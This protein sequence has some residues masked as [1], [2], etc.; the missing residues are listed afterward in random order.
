MGNYEEL[1][2]AVA[3]VVKTNGNQEITGAN[4][5]NVLLT[6]ISTIGSNRLFAGVANPTTN[7]GTPD[8]NVFYLAINPGTYVNF[9]AFVLKPG[10][11]AV[12]TNTASG[13]V[14][15]DLGVSSARQTLAIMGYIDALSVNKINPAT[16]TIGSYIN[17]NDT[18]QPEP[19]YMHTSFIKVQPGKQYC[20]K[21]LGANY[22][23]I[24][25]YDMN[26]AQQPT[27]IPNN[28]SLGVA[29]FVIPNNTEYVIINLNKSTLTDDQVRAQMFMNEGATILYQPY[30]PYSP[31]EVNGINVNALGFMAQYSFDNPSGQSDN[32][33]ID[34]VVL[35]GKGNIN[36]R[37]FNTLNNSGNIA[38]LKNNYPVKVVANSP[39]SGISAY[40]LEYEKPTQTSFIFPWLG[41]Y[42]SGSIIRLWTN[43]NVYTQLRVHFGFERMNNTATSEFVSFLPSEIVAG[44]TKTQNGAISQITAKVLQVSN[45]YCQLEF[46]CLQKADGNY[47]I[48]FL[49]YDFG[50]GS[51]SVS[52]VKYQ[53]FGFDE[54]INKQCSMPLQQFA[55]ILPEK[56]NAYDE[57]I[58]PGYV[59]LLK[60][61]IATP[62]VSAGYTNEQI[63]N[64]VPDILV[65]YFNSTKK[66]SGSTIYPFYYPLTGSKGTFGIWVNKT[67]YAGTL[68]LQLSLMS[69]PVQFIYVDVLPADFVVGKTFTKTGG[70]STFTAAILATNGDYFFFEIDYN[71][72]EDG[73]LR[74]IPYEQ[75]ADAGA[76][77]GKAYTYVG[78]A[79]TANPYNNILKY[80]LTRLQ[81][82]NEESRVKLALPDEITFEFN[83]AQQIF[84]YCINKAFNYKN[85][86]IQVLLDRDVTSGKDY[87]RYFQYQPQVTGI[88]NATFQLYDNSRN[89]L[90]EKV[91]KFNVV[92][93][94]TQP[95]AMTTVLFIGDSLTFYNRITDEFYR[96]L[97]SDDARTITPDT[98]SIYDVV[99]YAGR[100]WGNIQL[101]GTQKQNYMGWVGQTYHEGYSGWDWSN[102]LKTGSP[103]FIGGAV[104]FNAYLTNNSFDTPNIIYIGLGW[105]DQKYVTETSPG[106]FDVTTVMA[107]AR[108]FLTALTTQLPNAK[109]RLWTENVPGTRGGIGN[110]PYGAVEW[111]D[112]Q[113]AK[114]IQIAIAEGYRE[115]IKDFPTVGIV[116]STAMI[117]SENSLQETNAGINTRINNTEVLGKDYVHPADAG[118]FQIADTIISDFV[119]LI[120]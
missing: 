108:T 42:K 63:T 48:D 72:F 80:D 21:V 5:Q 114:L 43:Y 105:N 29:T 78:W 86:N 110:H 56:N 115:L 60:N 6:L 69:S 64:P 74:L 16:I 92:Q 22:C 118:F 61:N 51:G 65:N 41:Q 117:D 119:S 11:T 15:T 44:N 96:V 8:P 19:N 101:I 66:I 111:A 120:V 104:D 89:L 26:L 76:V 100:N 12:F 20:V 107:N 95:S 58:V 79:G 55:N 53:F 84:K 99:K 81:S 83:K 38:L 3:S 30:N 103:F 50:T 28:V 52:G 10:K 112:E 62:V 7:P 49:V 102:F 35:Q 17:G 45:G 57:T 9:D 113:R 33:I 2:A 27:L 59:E 1:K 87:N 97:T 82:Q 106:V 71:A 34:N 32:S 23:T 73:E 109:V 25:G 14:A 4:M 98:I 54:L 91:V 13:W 67:E 85:F 77:V 37:R 116:W 94:T 39:V 24:F 47:R 68:R 88:V 18:D 75:N 31:I 40:Y 70:Y 46:Q 90:D 93:R 36:T